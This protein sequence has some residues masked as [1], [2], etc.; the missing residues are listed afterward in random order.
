M[1]AFAHLGR[2]EIGDSM[3]LVYIWI[4]ITSDAFVFTRFQQNNF[5]F[6]FNFQTQ[7]KQTLDLFSQTQQRS[8]SLEEVFLFTVCLRESKYTTHIPNRKT[9]VNIHRVKV[10]TNLISKLEQIKKEHILNK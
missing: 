7:C 1:N 9:I 10:N 3:R 4:A 6:L 5:E 2:K 8:Q